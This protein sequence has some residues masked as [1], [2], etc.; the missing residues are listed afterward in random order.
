MKKYWYTYSENE[1]IIEMREILSYLDDLPDQLYIVLDMAID[2]AVY[3]YQNEWEG[4]DE[5]N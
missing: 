5:P 3:F 2:D 1:M 4:E